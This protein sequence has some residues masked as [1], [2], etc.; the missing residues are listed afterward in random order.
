M[1]K[2]NIL[3]ITSSLVLFLIG[4]KLN[5]YDIF[6]RLLFSINSNILLQ[7]NQLNTQFVNNLFF[8]VFLA[9]IP[10][11]IILIW[12]ILKFSEV[13]RRIL[14]VIILF[15]SILTLLAIRILITIQSINE[16][17]NS[18]IRLSINTENL[19][20]IL[21]MFAGLILGILMN[22]LLKNKK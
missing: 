11:A 22:I 13:K 18:K 5:L 12:K 8:S 20:L 17:D 21:T 15:I 14:S 9:S 2:I 4:F 10:L 6:I 19:H 1:K 3:L 16:F 7:N